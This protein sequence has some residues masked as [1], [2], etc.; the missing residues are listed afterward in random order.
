MVQRGASC[1]PRAGRVP[2]QPAGQGLPVGVP[3]HVR[4]AVTHQVADRPLGGAHLAPEVTPDSRRRA[5]RRF[6]A[7][8]EDD[9][10]HAA[11]LG[12]LLAVAGLEGHRIDER[13]R[14]PRRALRKVAASVE[15]LQGQVFAPG[16]EQ[17]RNLLHVGGA[18]SRSP[19]PAPA[20][21]HLS[22]CATPGGRQGHRSAWTAQSG[23]ARPVT[24]RD[25]A[26]ALL[27]TGGA[28]RW[29][30]GCIPAPAR[31]APVPSPARSLRYEP[32]GPCEIE[33]GPPAVFRA[34]G[35][36]RLSGG[37]AGLGVGAP[38]AGRRGWDAGPAGRLA[39]VPDGA[40]LGGARAAAGGRGGRRRA[41]APPSLLPRRRR[42]PS[43]RAGQRPRSRGPRRRRPPRPARAPRRRA[44]PGRRWGAGSGTR[45]TWRAGCS[46][47]A[48]RF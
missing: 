42:S 16:V 37:G 39:A 40:R 15:A 20:R 17:R 43:G 44:P 6:V 23:Q 10:R 9:R 31:G 48:C 11:Q 34:R 32:Y 13:A 26:T 29:G 2:D 25:R 41:G 5:R 38:P 36:G 1:P 35:G 30:R 27:G 22:G 4:Q 8:G 45:S 28:R 19:G 47:G 12:Q 33:S 24:R 18:S 14:L 21:R 3:A 46:A 7:S